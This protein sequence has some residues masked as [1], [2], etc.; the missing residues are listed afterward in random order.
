MKA[1]IFSAIAFLSLVVFSLPAHAG[2]KGVSIPGDVSSSNVT[3]AGTNTI[4]RSLAN[5]FTDIKNAADFGVV[6]DG[7]ALYDLNIT[8]G[9][10]T[11]SSTGYHF[12]SSDVGKTIVV[13]NSAETQGLTTTIASISGNN[14]VLTA[15]WTGT[16]ISGNTGRATFYTTDNTTALQLA[17]NSFGVPNSA[18]YNQQGFRLFIPNG[19]CA[20]G[21]ITIP[22]LSILECADDWNGCELFLKSNVNA[23]MIVSEG[24]AANTGTGHN[25]GTTAS[26]PSWFG[27]KNIHLD[28]NKVG[29][30]SG[31]CY[32]GYGN[33][34]M[35]LGEVLIENCHDDCMFTEASDASAYSA[36]DW[37]SQEE[38]VFQNVKTRNC[39]RYG[40]LDRGPHD[41]YT[42]NF[43]DAESASTGYRSETS[44]GFYAGV[45][46]IGKMH[47]Y[48]EADGTG[49]Y[50]GSTS[51]A[52]ELYP[53][54]ANLEINATSMKIGS[55]FT[56]ACGFLNKDC[57][58]ADAAATSMNIGYTNIIYCSTGGCN[59]GGTPNGIDVKNGANGTWGPVVGSIITPAFQTNII[60]NESSFMN[61]WGMLSN[62]TATNSDCLY[63]GGTYNIMNF[64]GYSCYNFA[65]FVADG[66][67]NI[68]NYMMF[69]SGGTNYT[70]SAIPASDTVNIQTDSGAN[71]YQQPGNGSTN[72][73]TNAG[74]GDIGEFKVSGGPNT[75][76]T[77]TITNASPGVITWTTHGLTAYQAVNFT[78]TG[79]LPTGL[80]VGTTYYVV[81][82]A[83]LTAN[84][85][86]VAT[87]IAN[88]VAGTQ[89]NTSSAGSGTQTGI[90]NATLS[91]GATKDLAGLS[92][93]AGDWDLMATICFTANAATTASVFD[94]GINNAAN[95]LP[96]PPGA[97]AYFQQSITVGAGGVEPCFS[98][99]PTKIGLSATTTEYL[100]SQATF[101]LNTMNAFGYISARR[102]R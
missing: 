97:G 47:T 94:G 80:T 76:A 67:N 42:S 79:G 58:I 62:A 77:V 36:T 92:L 84:S 2:L 38:G 6:C 95:T 8:N 49:M 90:S 45:S 33:M 69:K 54:F 86:T 66:G 11:L 93:T 28:G 24:F 10:K 89:V 35:M 64:T 72:A 82:G 48:A 13:S 12:T 4:S 37:K 60:K 41:K 99:G 32:A 5:H 23:D 34:Q 73:S 26:V 85:F 70:S 65:D 27:I 102:R 39:G 43:I 22:R 75:T 50:L 31:R 96:T 52:D 20:I 71:I 46:H 68:L 78:T 19:I 17:I 53:D 40:W 3:T 30:S 59:S 7:T 63:N 51:T 25:Y 44:A 56:T 57:V 98:I 55:I 101:A 14:A 15:N 1:S 9:T 83:S 81:P 87:S 16:T 100:S 21:Q 29:Q 18:G 91:T 88:A 61:M 74:A